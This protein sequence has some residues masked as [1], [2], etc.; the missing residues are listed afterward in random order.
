MVTAGWP[1]ISFSRIFGKGPSKG[2]EGVSTWRRVISAL[3]GVISNYKYSYVI[4]N[5]T[6]LGFGVPYFNTFFLK[7]PL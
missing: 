4:G 7:E 5:L 1:R 2:A 3:I 6:D